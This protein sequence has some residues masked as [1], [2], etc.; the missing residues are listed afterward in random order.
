MDYNEALAQ[1]KVYQKNG[2]VLGLEPT[3]RL[4]EKSG[5]KSGAT[6]IKV[7]GTNGKGT[8][9]SVLYSILK[10][11]GYSVGLY[12]SP[13]IRDFRERIKVDD[14]LISEKDFSELSVEL[15]G[16]IESEKSPPTF[17]EVTTV[18]ALKYFMNKS[19]DYIIL[20]AGLGGR[21]DS[22]NAVDAKYCIITNV[23]LD[24]MDY[25]GET[26]DK[27]AGEKAGIISTENIVVTAAEDIALKII[28]NKCIQLS[29]TLYVFGKDFN[30]ME[31]TADDS[32]IEF[33]YFD[34]FGSLKLNSSLLGVFQSRN[35]SCAV[36]MAKILNVSDATIKTGVKSAYISA[37]LELYSD[38][39]K[40]F[41]DVAHNPAGIKASTDFLKTV[42]HHKL[43]VVFSFSRDKDIESMTELL[44]FAD[45]LITA[46]FKGERSFD[47]N[48]LVDVENIKIKSSVAEGISYALSLAE[49]DDVV[50]VCGSF[51]TVND[52]KDYLQ[53]HLPPAE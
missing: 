6:V 53:V 13:E 37:R 31:I 30:V 39:P 45:E 44:S 4:L 51:H 5:Y 17:F 2:I 16:A 15:I 50:Y 48:I 43:F 1:L 18:L 7:A 25:L 3:K 33:T 11:A 12:T 38:N 19:V 46:P 41:L 52:A 21:L 22:T 23:D 35:I 24:H 36:R 40:I 28:L 10:A 32:R 49:K 29:A 27:I 9:A 8:T 26:I 14:N 47:P 34:S 42:R 20:E